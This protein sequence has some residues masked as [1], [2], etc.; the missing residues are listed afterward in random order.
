MAG[1]VGGAHSACVVSSANLFA[2]ESFSIEVTLDG[3][4]ADAA[5]GFAFDVR[6]EDDFDYLELRPWYGRV[7]V[8][9]HALGRWTRVDDYALDPAACAALFAVQRGQRLTLRASG[10]GQLDVLVDGVTLFRY[11]LGRTLRGGAAGLMFENCDA[12]ASERDVLEVH[13][14]GATLVR[15]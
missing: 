6:G 12:G 7:T 13:F 2:G 4:S 5:F 3:P 8:A 10:R 1:T 15:Q 11:D 14:R 9:E